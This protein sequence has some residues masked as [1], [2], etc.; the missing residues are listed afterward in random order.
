MEFLRENWEALKTP[1][2]HPFHKIY[3]T[4]YKFYGQRISTTGIFLIIF[5]T[6]DIVKS[7]MECPE[8]TFQPLFGVRTV[9]IAHTYMEPSVIRSENH[10]QSRNCFLGICRTPEVTLFQKAAYSGYISRES[11]TVPTI[12]VCKIVY[13]IVTSKV[14][15]NLKQR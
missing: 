9:Y 13:T 12:P 1:R 3:I 6:I 4:Y 7:I 15:Q 14:I 10:R 5:L 11:A 2:S 8:I